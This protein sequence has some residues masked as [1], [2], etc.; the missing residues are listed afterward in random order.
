MN[1]WMAQASDIPVAL[2]YW[3]WAGWGLLSQP[4]NDKEEIIPVVTFLTPL[5]EYSSD[6][7]DR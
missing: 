2:S 6:L 3:R 5:A 7:K 1:A 4:K